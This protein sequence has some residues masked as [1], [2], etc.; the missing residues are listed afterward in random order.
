MKIFIRGLCC[1]EMQNRLTLWD[2]K[3][4]DSKKV[5]ASIRIDRL[6]DGEAES[7]SKSDS[8]REGDNNLNNIQVKLL[9]LAP[10]AAQDVK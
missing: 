7:P 6:E 9:N 1:L 4:Y 10:I 5:I 2:Y 8:T 3:E